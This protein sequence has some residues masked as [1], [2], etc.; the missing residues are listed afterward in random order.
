MEQRLP[1]ALLEVE[2]A[3]LTLS[4]ERRLPTALLEV[5]NAML[6][7]SPDPLSFPS[8]DAAQLTG[9]AKGWPSTAPGLAPC[10]LPRSLRPVNGD[11][12][13]AGLD[14]K[15]RNEVARSSILTV[16]LSSAWRFGHGS[17]LPQLAWTHH[18]CEVAGGIVFHRI[19]D[20]PERGSPAGRLHP[21]QWQ[22][23]FGGSLLYLRVPLL[24]F[25]S[26]SYFFLFS[27]PFS[28]CA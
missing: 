13:I 14:E 11:G 23:D 6:T 24:P 4:M 18:D 26:L 1:T 27:Y 21:R 15:L 2:D 22:T 9:A 17:R 7:L 5:K 20:V 10:T 12:T 16:P 28:A 3:V 19:V 8:I 25:L